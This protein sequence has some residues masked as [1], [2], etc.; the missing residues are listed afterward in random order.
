VILIARHNSS[1]DDMNARFWRKAAGRRGGRLSADIVAKVVL[2]GW[3]KILR[4]VGA[5]LM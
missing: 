5:V 4:A 1:A 2:H 3:S